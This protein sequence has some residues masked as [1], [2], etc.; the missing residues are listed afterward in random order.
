MKKEFFVTWL[1]RFFA[2]V[3]VCLLVARHMMEGID[4]GEKS[5][6]LYAALAF[7]VAAVIVSQVDKYRRKKGK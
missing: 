4:D 7:A 3:A 2:I 6:M 1:H 5:M